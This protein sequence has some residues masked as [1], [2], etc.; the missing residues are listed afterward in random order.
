MSS[1]RS[2]RT[3]TC[4]KCGSLAWLPAGANRSGARATIALPFSVR[5]SARYAE[6]LTGVSRMSLPAVSPGPP[7][8]EVQ[9]QASSQRVQEMPMI[10]VRASRWR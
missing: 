2:N 4:T 10:V 5:I 6:S 9:K 8:T 3:G 1:S 7:P